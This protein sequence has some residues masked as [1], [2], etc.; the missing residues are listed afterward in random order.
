MT[1]PRSVYSRIRMVLLTTNPKWIKWVK[2]IWIA[3]LVFLLFFGTYILGVIYNPFNLFG[4]MPSLHEIENPKQDLSTEVIAA[5]G[6]SLGRF[7]RFN[8]SMVEYEELS[9]ILV[10]TLILSEDHRFYDH[11]GLDLPAYLRVLKGF[12][13]FSAQGGGSTLTQQTAK[14]LFQTRGPE[15]R[16]RLGNL[17]NSF[18]LVISKTKEWIIAIRLEQNFTKEEI[19]TLYLNTVP[20]NNNAYGIKIAAETY[21]RK[22]P[23]LLNQVESALLVGMLQGTYLFNP[24]EF[25]ERA[26]EKRNDVLKKLMDHNVLSK[27]TSASLMAQPLNLKFSFQSH[28]TGLAPYFRMALQ[29]E[30]SEWCKRRGIDMNQSGLKVYTTIDSRLQWYAELSMKEH[31][32]NVQKAFDEEWGARNPWVDEDG[33]EVAGFLDRKLRQ[34]DEYRRLV[35]AYDN[36]DSVNY[37]VNTKRRFRTF[38]WDGNERRMMTLREFVAYQSR[39]LHCGV[40]SM[41]PHTGAVK[42]WVGGIDHSFFQYDHVRQGSRQAGSTFKAFVYGLAMENEFSPCQPF[43]DITPAI[44]ANGKLYQPKNA[45][46]TY[47]DGET[48]TLRRALAKSLNSVTMQLMTK[49]QPQ[50]VVDFAHRIGIN[51]TLDPVYSL[52]LGTSDVTLYDMVGAYSTFVNQGIHTKPYYLVRIEDRYGNVLESFNPEQ[53][54]VI[55]PSTA[56]KTVYLLQGVVDEEGGSASALSPAVKSDNEVGGKTGTTDN[57]SDGWFIGITPNLVTGV[58]VGGDERSIHFPNW[59]ESSGART[60]LPIFDLY[61][62]KVYRNTLL[63]YRKGV[64]LRPDG[65]DITLDCSKISPSESIE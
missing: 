49:L 3:T 33:N 19:I 22:S 42:A 10:R 38:S 26:R 5:D 43:R 25:P 13:T 53:R 23:K 44:N 14:N 65:L 27:E 4:P 9:P 1:S 41:D 60:A 46:G 64:F 31:M 52:G 6:A 40:M 21:F 59:G 20:F 28:N 8:R 29:Q 51:T 36:P 2:G 18:D 32:T 24:I 48:Y 12:V 62:Q 17:F 45:N 55:S 16:G 57:G 34:S 56:Y 39:F 61:M 35:K 54:Q 37:Y 63:G 7:F 15:L 30:I 58:W 50:N 47:G 11:S